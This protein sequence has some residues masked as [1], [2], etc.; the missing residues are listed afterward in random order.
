MGGD[1]TSCG[2]PIKPKA[3]NSTQAQLEVQHYRA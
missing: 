1:Y 2:T 3:R